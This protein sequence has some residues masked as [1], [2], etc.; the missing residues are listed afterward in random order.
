MKII[1]VVVTFNRKDLLKKV[2]DAI[3]EQTVRPDELIVVNNNSTDG[4][5]DYLNRM[6]EDCENL[7]H[8]ALEHN[9]GGA[10]GFSHGIRQAY[11]RGADWIWILDDDAIPRNDTLE[12]LVRSDV[13]DYYESRTDME[14]GFLA[15]RVDWTNGEICNMNIPVAARD[16]PEMHGEFPFCTKLRSASF[17]SILIN[18]TAV[19][20]VG[21][22]VK[23]FFIWFDDVEYTGRITECMPAYYITSS[24]IVHHTET[25]MMPADYTYLNRSNL[26]K[27]Q[28]GMRN[29]VA[30][31]RYTSKLGFIE[32]I[33]LIL[34][35]LN[36][37]LKAKKSASL[38]IP[39]LG[40]GV[41]GFFYD[42]VKLIEYPHE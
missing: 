35:R 39:V 19:K 1:C 8:I 31:L 32:G 33:A 14:L 3:Q 11:E 30:V 38:I 10:W 28:Y 37:L 25:N 21:Y 17:V 13:F 2:V 18:R 23:E 22:P 36:H 29:E 20:K 24:V 9:R 26:W 7:C 34:R 4:T 12:K 42:Y 16:W 5:T 27:F 41:K 40:A 6:E 15:S